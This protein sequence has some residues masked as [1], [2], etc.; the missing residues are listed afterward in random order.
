VSSVKAHLL[1]RYVQY[2]YKEGL[3]CVFSAACAAGAA[4]AAGAPFSSS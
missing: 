3:L 2:K 4:G 1:Y